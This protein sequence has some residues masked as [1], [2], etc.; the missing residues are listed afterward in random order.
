MPPQGVELKEKF[1]SAL[2]PPLGATSSFT[3]QL[4]SPS[5]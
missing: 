5:G 4:R 3:I 2:I 1:A